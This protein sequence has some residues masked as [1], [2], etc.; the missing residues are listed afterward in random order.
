MLEMGS[1]VE[2]ELYTTT[3]LGSTHRIHDFIVEYLKRMKDKS[4]NAPISRQNSDAMRAIAE[5]SSH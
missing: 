5:V 2:I 4:G 3:H 1:Q